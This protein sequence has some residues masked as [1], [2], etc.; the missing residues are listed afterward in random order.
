MTECMA[1]PAENKYCLTLY[2]QSLLTLTLAD[3]VCI[4]L[5]K[6]RPL[7]PEAWNASPWSEPWNVTPPSYLAHTQ[8]TCCCSPS[9][10]P[11][12]PR[13]MYLSLCYTHTDY[14]VGK[15]EYDLPLQYH[16]SCVLGEKGFPY[17]DQFPSC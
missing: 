10:G 3:P 1:H 17:G 14:L 6:P 12:G 4:L 16:H 11:L 5:P 15:R 2:R 9:S 8:A 7:S 13:A